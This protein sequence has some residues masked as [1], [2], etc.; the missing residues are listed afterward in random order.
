MYGRKMFMRRLV[1][2]HNPLSLFC[3]IKSI[4]MQQLF[5]QLYNQRPQK[6]IWLNRM[7]LTTNLSDVKIVVNCNV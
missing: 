3:T 5:N 7:K 2:I 4:Y 6:F 1:T